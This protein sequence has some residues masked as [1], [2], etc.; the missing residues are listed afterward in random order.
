MGELNS[1]QIRDAILRLLYQLH[2]RSRSMDGQQIG[3]QDLQRRMKRE[4][5]LTQSEVAANPGYPI[6]QEFVRKIVTPRTFTTRS[7]TTQSSERVTYKISKA[8]IDRVEGDSEFRSTS[9]FSGINITAINGL[10]AVGQGNRQK[11]V[12]NQFESLSA[13]LDKLEQAIRESHLAEENKLNALA[14]IETIDA[15]LAK[16]EANPTIIS[17]A[18]RALE[19][20]V[21][22]GKA[23]E[24]AVKVGE[25]ITRLFGDGYAPPLP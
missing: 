13:Q 22:A 17:Q 19:H 6:E 16:R 15:Q 18:W 9:P 21:T 7:G 3:I 11:M 23:A 20:I 2:R 14:E 24:L 1:D 5:G 12:Q 25:T 4:L 8:G 10:V